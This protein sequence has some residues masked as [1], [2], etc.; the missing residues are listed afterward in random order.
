MP[1]LIC[2]KWSA[3]RRDAIFTVMESCFAAW[4]YKHT[5]KTGVLLLIYKMLSETSGS[6]GNILWELTGGF[7]LRSP[8]SACF[9]F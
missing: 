4:I 2:W 7:Q 8:T 1:H 5:F 9:T 6:S 3:V